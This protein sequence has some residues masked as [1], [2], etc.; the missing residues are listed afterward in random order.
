M[1]ELPVKLHSPGYR[2]SGPGTN[3]K[4]RLACGEHGISELGEACCEHDK[5]KDNENGRKG[6][7]ILRGKTCK[8]VKPWNSGVSERAHAAAVVAAMKAKSTLVRR[9]CCHRLPRRRRHQRKANIQRRETAREKVVFHVNLN[10][11]HVKQLMVYTSDRNV[12]KPNTHIGAC[13]VR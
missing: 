2:F 1:H 7:R 5:Y 13:L 8:L 3:L 9:M 6:E 11:L 10:L 4:N 12:T